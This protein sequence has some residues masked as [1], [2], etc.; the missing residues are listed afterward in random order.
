MNFSR[1]RAK[2]YF[3]QANQLELAVLR[4]LWSRA[5]SRVLQLLAI[6]MKLAS[7]SANARKHGGLGK[8]LTRHLHCEMN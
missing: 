2:M 7:Y 3:V 4:H 6:S 8:L 5:R 1:Q